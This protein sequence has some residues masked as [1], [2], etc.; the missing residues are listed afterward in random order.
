MGAM[1][2]KMDFCTVFDVE[3]SKVFSSQKYAKQK[4]FLVLLCKI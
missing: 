4:K 1:V 3:K 2:L